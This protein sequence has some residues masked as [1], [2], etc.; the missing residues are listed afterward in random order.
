[1]ICTGSHQVCINMRP[2][3]FDHMGKD[4]GVYLP[5]GGFVEMPTLVISC[6]VISFGKMGNR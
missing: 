2:K 1:M 6:C 3:M 4:S 5:F